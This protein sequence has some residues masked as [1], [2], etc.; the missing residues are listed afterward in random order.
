MIASFIYS[1][2]SHKPLPS[3]CVY[4]ALPHPPYQ[5]QS[6]CLINRP[7]CL[8]ADPFPR[9]VPWR[10]PPW[11]SLVP[12]ASCVLAAPGGTCGKKWGSEVAQAW[13]WDEGRRDAYRHSSKRKSCQRAD[14]VGRGSCTHEPTSQV[15][16]SVS[17]PTDTLRR[18]I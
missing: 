14:G 13:R 17:R 11:S 3:V 8:L 15:E 5:G 9:A 1:L 10:C 18:A 2:F 4:Q 6:A 12:G 7:S 16:I